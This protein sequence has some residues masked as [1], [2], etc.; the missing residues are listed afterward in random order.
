MN[1][2]EKA[3][4]YRRHKLIQMNIWEKADQEWHYRRHIHRNYYIWPSLFNKIYL[5]NSSSIIYTTVHFAWGWV[6]DVSIDL[7]RNDDTKVFLMSLI[8]F[9]KKGKACDKKKCIGILYL[10]YTGG[11][12]QLRK[13]LV[14]W[15][16][17]LLQW[18]INETKQNKKKIYH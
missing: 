15:K 6:R 17:V 14:E 4:H 10:L 13:Y 11:T 3:D 18:K 9:S 2:W 1:R 7:L 12:H 8:E 16:T 5:F